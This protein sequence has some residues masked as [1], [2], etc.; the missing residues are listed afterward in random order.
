MPVMD[1]SGVWE[2]IMQLIRFIDFYSINWYY[3]LTIITIIIIITTIIIIS[4]FVNFT[5][6]ITCSTYFIIEI[7]FFKINPKY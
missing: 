2:V 1:F 3:L 7:N 6:I 5:I 4:N